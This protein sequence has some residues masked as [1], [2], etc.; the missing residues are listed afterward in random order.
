MSDDKQ[1]HED[2]SYVRSVLDKSQDRANPAGTYFL[3]AVISFFGYAIIDFAP[4]KTGVYW[5]IA[6]P[7][8]GVLSAVIGL[9][10]G[11][12]R[13]QQSKQEDRGD[14]LHWMGLF[15]AILLL[16]PLVATDVFPPYELPRVILLFVAF[17]YFLSGVHQ[18]RKMIPV[19]LVVAGC[20]LLSVFGRGLPY[21]WTLVAAVLA[22]SLV[23]AGT[24][25]SA[26][27]RRAD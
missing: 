24:L 11:R 15:G 3:W 23:A 6:G 18:D 12:A 20:Y 9:R 10:A 21:L 26:R 17:A 19:G 27:A 22:G 2:L 16:L 8:G 14:F 13:G 1:V 7:V 25:S 4:E 5:A